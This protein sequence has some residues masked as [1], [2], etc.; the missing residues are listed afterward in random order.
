MGTE[1][2]CTVCGKQ[3]KADAI[4]LLC[5]ECRKSDQHL[6]GIIRDFLYDNPGASVNEVVQFTGVTSSVVLK[7]LREGRIET[8]GS[9]KLL[10]CEVCGK[11]IAYGTQCQECKQKLTHSFQSASKVKSGDTK[12]KMYTKTKKK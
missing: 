12:Q 2:T 10:N 3:F 9:I 5:F 4:S 7:Y 6:F 1:S 11:P 8:I